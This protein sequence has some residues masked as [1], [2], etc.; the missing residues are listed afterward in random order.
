MIH[1]CLH[2]A[3]VC[4][5]IVVEVVAIVK[6]VVAADVAMPAHQAVLVDVMALANGDVKTLVKEPVVVDV[7]PHVQMDVDGVADDL[8]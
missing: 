2:L 8:F 5:H 4:L 6:V 7:N 3:T 1:L